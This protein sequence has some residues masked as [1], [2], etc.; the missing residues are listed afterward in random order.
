MKTRGYHRVYKRRD[1]ELAMLIRK[2]VQQEGFTIPGAR[3][4]LR[5]LGKDKMT[6]EPDP[7]A[8]R[9]VALRADLL[10][11]RRELGDLLKRLDDFAEKRTADRESVATVTS[12]I[13]SAVPVVKRSEKQS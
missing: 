4:R 8:S 7:E 5:E 13:P 2:L 1:V 3:K 6:S 12:A 10:A 11:V 9:E